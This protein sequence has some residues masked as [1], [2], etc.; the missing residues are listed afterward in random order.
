MIP[1][2]IWTIWLGGKM[3]ELVRGCIET[4][5][6]PGYEHCL[7]TLDNCYRGSQ[8]VNDAIRAER[9]V[10]AADWLRMHYLYTEGGIYL[11]ADMEVL[12]GKNFDDLLD[13][14]LFVPR[15]ECGHYGN[16]GLGSIAGQPDLKVY[17]DRVESNFK[18]DGD[19]VYDPG[20]RAFSDV[21]W[22]AERSSERSSDKS[23]MRILTPDYFF[24]YNHQTN[25]TEITANTRVFHHYAK[26]WVAPE[27]N[28]L[29]LV[30]IIIPTLGRPNGLQ[31]CIDSI[32]RLNYPHHRVETII[33]D[34]PDTVPE[35]VR[36]GLEQSHGNLI[37]YAAN[38]MEFT[39]DSLWL[40]VDASK[41]HGL[42]AFASGPLYPDRGNICE[43]FLIRRDMIEKVG[44]IFSTRFHHVGCDNL[45]WAKCSALGEAYRCE[46][47]RVLHHHFTAGAEMD[48]VY[49]KGWSKVEEDREILREELKEL[50]FFKQ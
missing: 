18:G 42:V 4:Q 36:R 31:R 39:P 45:L 22:L 3:T 12:P 35:K 14:D 6:L 7:I 9:W 40:A 5:K 49:Q 27:F 13:C 16:C 26:S 24:P 43:H 30:S 28:P 41:K 34:G 44:E 50:E 47:A 1:K 8:Y 32:Q 20:I 21:F 2:K 46:E 11:D 10:K 23:R 25:R 29:P 37:V 19:L 38:D 33:V 15:E 17:L 48:D